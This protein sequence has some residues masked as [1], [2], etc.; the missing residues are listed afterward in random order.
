MVHYF[1]GGLLIGAGLHVIMNA[2]AREAEERVRE[3]LAP[4]LETAELA[5]EELEGELEAAKAAK[6]TE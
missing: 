2:A 1:I 5:I 3:E 6:V 4:E